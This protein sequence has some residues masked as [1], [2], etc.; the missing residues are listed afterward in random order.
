MKLFIMQSSSAP[1]HFLSLRSKYP[2]HFVLKYH[3]SLFSLKM[4]DHVPHLHKTTGKIIVSVLTL[5][6]VN[7]SVVFQH[8]V[9]CR[10]E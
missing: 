9:M 5:S 8:A 10:S 3:Q 4:N 1:Y 6:L 2:Q 7:Y